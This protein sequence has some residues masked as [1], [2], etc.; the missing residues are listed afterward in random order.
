MGY[1]GGGFKEFAMVDISNNIPNG[2]TVKTVLQG[3]KQG[4][5]FQPWMKSY[6][7]G[8]GLK[9]E[10]LT[11]PQGSTNPNNLHFILP[12]GWRRD[13]KAFPDDGRKMG[14]LFLEDYKARAVIGYSLRYLHHT[15]EQFFADVDR[16]VRGAGFVV[17]ALAERVPQLLSLLTLSPSDAVKAEYLG[18]CGP[19]YTRLRQMGYADL[20]LR[21]K[22]QSGDRAE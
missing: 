18:I 7:V 8:E 11:I 9:F 21:G 22:L 2:V 5:D 20:E 16:A 17:D 13:K 4:A 1:N 10:R 14:A 6:A 3:L 19:I 12:G 15:S